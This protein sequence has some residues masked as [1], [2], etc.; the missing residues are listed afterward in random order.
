M[1]ELGGGTDDIRDLRLVSEALVA[2]LTI[3]TLHAPHIAS[4]DDGEMS[5]I[6]RIIQEKEGVIRRSLDQLVPAIKPAIKPGTLLAP[7]RLSASWD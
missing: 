4:P 3:Q 2:I 5:G 6:E 1:E 7:R